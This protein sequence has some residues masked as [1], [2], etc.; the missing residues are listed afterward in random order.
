[1][2]GSSSRTR[3]LSNRGDENSRSNRPFVC[4]SPLRAWS[5]RSRSRVSHA[6]F[7]ACAAWSCR[8][9]SR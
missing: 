8:R 7:P 3:P 4:P 1:L 9:L 2:F 5:S 6:A